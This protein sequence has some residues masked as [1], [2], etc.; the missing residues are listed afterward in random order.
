MN[1]VQHMDEPLYK[2]RSPEILNQM[3]QKIIFSGELQEDQEKED[4][5]E[6]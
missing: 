1:L 5:E 4:A 3:R 2:V 6:S